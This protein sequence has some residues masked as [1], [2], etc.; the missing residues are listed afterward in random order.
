MASD[1]IQPA[2]ASKRCLW[3]S[4]AMILGGSGAFIA[5]ALDLIYHGQIYRWDEP[6]AVYLHQ[7]GTP[8]GMIFFSA[9]SGLGEFRVLFLYALLIGGILL[10]RRHTYIAL[11]WGI[12]FF[13]CAV[14]NE[15]LKRFFLIPRPTELTF[16][17]FEAYQGYSF[18]SGHTMGAA[19]A[20][21]VTVVF[22]SRF[23]ILSPRETWMA[24]AAACALSISVAFALMY[25]GVHTLIDVLAGLAVS[26]G[27]V[28]VISLLFDPTFINK[29][30]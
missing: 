20:A 27:W 26:V 13:G 25:V 4:L 3:P 30:G 16:Y 18:P 29:K 5:M 6:I 11:L 21:G 7:H 10:Y 19:I 15:V 28:G 17:I 14:I 12:S 24:S 1:P 23:R 2:S 22:A 9:L 8:W